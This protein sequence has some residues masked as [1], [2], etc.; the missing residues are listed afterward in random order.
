MLCR[1]AGSFEQL[2][3]YLSKYF[4]NIH[5]EQ[6]STSN[7]RTAVILGE[8]Y[9]VR[10]NSNAAILMI[11]KEVGVSETNLEIISYAGASGVL[12]LSFGAHGSYVHRIRD[13]LQGAGL[14]VEVMK[15]IHDYDSSSREASLDR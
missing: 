1:V 2:V 3:Q 15:E 7:G 9:F 8:S 4:G 10:A 12:D 14:N 6:W 11:L 13:S 5:N